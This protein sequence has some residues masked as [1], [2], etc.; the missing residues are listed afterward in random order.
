MIPVAAAGETT[1]EESASAAVAKMV[2]MSHANY[3]TLL[4]QTQ[5]K[6]HLL[7]F[8]LFPGRYLLLQ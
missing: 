2:I 4:T 1:E 5:F 7:H 8:P 6:G 3:Y